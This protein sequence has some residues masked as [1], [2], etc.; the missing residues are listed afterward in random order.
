MLLSSS[1][2]GCSFLKSRKGCILNINVTEEDLS[3]K[4][5]LY[6]LYKIQKSPTPRTPFISIRSLTSHDMHMCFLMNSL[7]P[8]MPCLPNT[9]THTCKQMHTWKRSHKIQQH[10]ASG[11][12]SAS[13]ITDCQTSIFIEVS[14]SNERHALPAAVLVSLAVNS[15]SP[16]GETY[17]KMLCQFVALYGFVN[18]VCSKCIL[19]SAWLGGGWVEILPCFNTNTCSSLFFKLKKK[20]HRCVCVSVFAS[21]VSGRGREPRGR[22]RGVTYKRL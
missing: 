20:M 14:S 12:S 16:P 9:H 10:T 19:T 2:E 13:Y 22:D 11:S 18:G 4:N 6:I 7:T 15:P 8:Y 3:L 1:P 21:A 17:S 5:K